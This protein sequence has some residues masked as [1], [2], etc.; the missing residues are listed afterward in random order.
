MLTIVVTFVLIGAAWYLLAGWLQLPGRIPFPG[1]A[2]SQPAS[3]PDVQVV[4]IPGTWESRADDDPYAPWG[5]PAALLLDVTTPLQE[6]FA[7]R[8]GG[9]LH[10]AVR[11]TVLES[12]RDSAGRADSYNKS[13]SEGTS[14]AIDLM[15]EAHRGMPAHE[16]R[17]PR[18]LAGCG[19]RG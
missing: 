12:D 16:L 17:P 3:C 6:Q 11:R 9:C 14:R 10:R 13:R 7:G 5:N 4:S 8:A 19:Y 15:S 2:Q 1:G 18:I